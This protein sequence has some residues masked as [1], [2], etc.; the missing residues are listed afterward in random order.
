MR[1]L[2]LGGIVVAFLLAGIGAVVALMDGLGPWP[3]APVLLLGVA[4]VRLWLA[5]DL[6]TVLLVRLAA[7]ATVI[8]LAV[9]SAELAWYFVPA[10]FIAL[11]SA[12][13]TSLDLRAAGARESRH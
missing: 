11:L 8:C 4:A 10:G 2:A 12:L 1:R 13:L 3:M 5:Q 6:I 7:L 9:Y